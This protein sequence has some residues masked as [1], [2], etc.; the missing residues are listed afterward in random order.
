MKRWEWR[1]YRSRKQDTVKVCDSITAH[2]NAWVSF[3]IQLKYCCNNTSPTI[4][5]RKHFFLYARNSYTKS[6]TF[7]LLDHVQVRSF[8][9]NKNICPSHRKQKIL[10]SNYRLIN[11]NYFRE[12]KFLKFAFIDYFPCLYRPYF[13]FF[14]NSKY[15]SM[16]LEYEQ[17]ILIVNFSNTMCKSRTLNKL[18]M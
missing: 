12:G 9:Q 2:G 4:L 7:N 11:V 16:H 13:P 18:K 15:I 3:Q 8:D 1:R 14:K 10:F 6:N 17:M 5:F